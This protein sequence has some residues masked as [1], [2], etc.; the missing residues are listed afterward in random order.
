MLGSDESFSQKA[1]SATSGTAHHVSCARSNSRSAYEMQINPCGHEATDNILLD[2][3]PEEYESM[4]S[5]C[6]NADV[7]KNTDREG[8]YWEY[9]RTKALH[10]A[11][12]DEHAL[13]GD[14]GSVLTLDE[15]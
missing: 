1:Y 14:L 9:F 6:E 10:K 7:V 2:L 3:A 8:Y 15:K 4:K 11:M 13:L 12:H 5:Y